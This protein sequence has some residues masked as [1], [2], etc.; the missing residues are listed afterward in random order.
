MLSIRNK[1]VDFYLEKIDFP[2][3]ILFLKREN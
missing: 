1:S 2:A 3:E